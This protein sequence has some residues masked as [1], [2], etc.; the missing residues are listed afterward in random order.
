MA[1]QNRSLTAH[2]STNLATK[3]TS[4][5]FL[6]LHDVF[7]LN[8]ELPKLP[9]PFK[10]DSGVSGG[11]SASA[12]VAQGRAA[13]RSAAALGSSPKNSAKAEGTGTGTVPT[14]TALSGDGIFLKG[15]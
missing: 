14:G 8:A 2:L 9:R 1:I 10:P 11:D 5:D 6:V 15:L 12:T 13:P 7:F 3:R 4:S